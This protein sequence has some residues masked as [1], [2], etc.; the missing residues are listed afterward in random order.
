MSTLSR[1]SPMRSTAAKK[2]PGKR[3]SN[4]L[5]A[6]EIAATD[7]LRV[8]EKVARGLRVEEGT[9]EQLMYGARHQRIAVRMALMIEALSDEPVA[10]EKQL[11]IVRAALARIPVQ[12]DSR[13]L[14]EQC[15]VAD[16]DEEV[17]EGAYDRCPCMAHALNLVKAY[18]TERALNLERRSAIA[19]QWGIA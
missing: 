15:D 5:P 13:K 3:I 11:A 7:R 19:N 1:I 4:Y 9:A 14:A 16:S 2:W 8:S 10:L 18:D 17:A 6:P 12:P